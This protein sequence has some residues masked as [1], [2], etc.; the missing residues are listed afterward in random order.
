MLSPLI[1]LP[2]LP[3]LIA[4]PLSHPHPRSSP[5]LNSTYVSPTFSQSLH[6]IDQYSVESIHYLL[7]LP[8]N[9]AEGQPGGWVGQNGYTAIAQWD[10]QQGTRTFYRAVK[11]AEDEYAT[12]PGGCYADWG[13]EL[14]DCY[15]DDAGW[16]GLASLQAWEA[17]GD[18][19]FLTRAKGVFD[20]SRVFGD[21]EAASVLLRILFIPERNSSSTFISWTS[22][23]ARPG[24]LG[25]S[26]P[27]S[28]DYPLI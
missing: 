9:T 12:N 3:P 28:P 14:V 4:S 27:I 17:Y 13:V 6:N 16:A 18:E 19:V 24:L 25:L 10:Y 23:K 22:Q 21:S 20:V 1:L 26:S 7:S 11:A 15:N 5:L 2:L 8:N